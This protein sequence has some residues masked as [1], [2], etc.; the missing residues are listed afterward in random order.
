MAVCVSAEVQLSGVKPEKDGAEQQ[1]QQL[2]VCACAAE[3]EPRTYRLGRFDENLGSSELELV[4]VHVDGPQQVKD[5]LFFIPSPRGPGLF[6]QDGVPVGGGRPRW[7]ETKTLRNRSGF[8][9]E[10]WIRWM[11]PCRSPPWI[12]CVSSH[13]Q[14]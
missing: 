1:Q 6:R 9:L 14:F 7:A 10:E 4:L 5:P 3:S 8:T 13:L 11:T 12:A 2:C